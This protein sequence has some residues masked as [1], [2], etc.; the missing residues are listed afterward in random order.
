MSTPSSISQKL[1]P[2][3]P[4]EVRLHLL[5]LILQELLLL[6]V[7]DLLDLLQLL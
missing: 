3:T 5:L 4:T 2:V 1:D 6:V 7:L